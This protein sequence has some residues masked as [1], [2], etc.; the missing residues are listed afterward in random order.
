MPPKNYETTSLNQEIADTINHTM[1]HYGPSVESESSSPYTYGTTY[2]SP[3]DSAYTGATI[4]MND[5]DAKID[6]LKEAIQQMKSALGLDEEEQKKKD[7]KK[8]DNSKIFIALKKGIRYLRDGSW[9]N[10]KDTSL[11][12]DTDKQEWRIR[13]APDYSVATCMYNKRWKIIGEK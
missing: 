7:T 2:W 4:S 9:H 5:T 13:V 1:W 12:F 8:K 6:E 3:S 11:F 10:S